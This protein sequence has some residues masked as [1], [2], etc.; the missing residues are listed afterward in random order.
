MIF[1]MFNVI[2]KL[3]LLYSNEFKLSLQLQKCFLTASVALSNH[4]QL[5]SQHERELSL[6]KMNLH[7]GKSKSAMISIINDCDWHEWC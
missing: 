6:R 4:W 7:Q 3:K 2:T 5:M 1:C